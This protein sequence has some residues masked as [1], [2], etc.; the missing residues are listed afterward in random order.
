MRLEWKIF[1][2]INYFQFIAC[3][4][5]LCSLL[6]KVID[7]RMD[8]SGWGAVAIMILFFSSVIFNSLL[9]L[10]ILRKYF[11]DTLLPRKILR[12]QNICTFFFSIDILAM[13]FIVISETSDD[14]PSKYETTTIIA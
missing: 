7:Q 2:L 12:L 10:H 14:I 1:R 3:I 9:N 11:P 8:I 4:I 13:L 6:A 5:I